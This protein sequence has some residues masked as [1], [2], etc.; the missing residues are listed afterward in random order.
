MQS[1]TYNEKYADYLAANNIC[2][3]TPEKVAA[4][5]ATSN[6]AVLA[7]VNSNDHLSFGSAAWLLTQTCDASFGKGL[8]S[9]TEAAFTRYIT[10]C[11]HT[12]QDPNRLAIW[13]KVMALKHW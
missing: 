2:G 1:Y 11:V 13:E 5:N 4:A 3:I 12:T 9:G 8:A 6:D 7:L 10:D